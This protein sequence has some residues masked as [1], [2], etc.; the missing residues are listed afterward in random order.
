MELLFGQMINFWSPMNKNLKPLLF[1]VTADARQAIVNYL[2]F[3]RLNYSV[4]TN[5]L[6]AL[7]DNERRIL[8][9]LRLIRVDDVANFETYHSF[10]EIVEIFGKWTAMYP[11]NF[12]ISVIG[13][14]YEKKPI[15]AVV[16]AGSNSKEMYDGTNVT[17]TAKV[18]EII[19]LECGIHAREWLSPAT[20]LYIANILLTN[21][22]DDASLLSNYD[23]HIV[24]VINADGYVFTWNSNRMWRKNRNPGNFP[25]G[26]CY[27]VDLNRNFDVNHCGE[28][29]SRLP[30]HE[31][32]CGRSA[33]SENETRAIRDYIISLNSTQ[34]I[35]L[36][37]SVHSYSEI[38]MYPYSYTTNASPKVSIYKEASRRATEA[39]KQTHGEEYT[40]GQSSEV[41]YECSGASDDWI[42]SQNLADL[43]FAIELR[44]KGDYGFLIPP[45]FIK[46]TA[47]EI[48]NGIKA[49]AF[50]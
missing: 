46:P 41:L 39:I 5:H 16:I 7:I 20:C 3:Y 36:Y 12:K 22:N 30:C 47:E 45:K 23:F 21:T 1:T 17:N 38:W 18:K 28:P 26:P 29:L 15:F 9:K 37:F 34:R 14:T 11:N 4:L 49:V 32:F 40:Y 42:E 10:N 31:T 43:S 2:S 24:P 6:K 8:A 13:H 35:K 27:G 44:D 33:F 25:F 19:F 50:L 48:W